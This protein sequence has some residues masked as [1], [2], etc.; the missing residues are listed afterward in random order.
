VREKKDSIEMG[1]T[2]NHRGMTMSSRI[3]LEVEEI[4]DSTTTGKMCKG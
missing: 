2:V 1:T 3:I 4:P